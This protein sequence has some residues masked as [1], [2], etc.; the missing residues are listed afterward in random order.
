MTVIQWFCLMIGTK[1]EY[2]QTADV[3]ITSNIQ[4]PQSSVAGELIIVVPEPSRQ[5][6]SQPDLPPSYDLVMKKPPPYSTLEQN[7]N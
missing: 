7:K 3:S 2:E 5:Q 1:L 6:S 4:I